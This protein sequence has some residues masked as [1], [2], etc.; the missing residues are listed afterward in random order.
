MRADHITET[1]DQLRLKP[2]H[3]SE[4]YRNRINFLRRSLLEE[5]HRLDKHLRHP[6][7]EV[8][9]AE[10]RRAATRK[11]IAE[12]EERVSLPNGARPRH[13]LR[14]RREVACVGAGQEYARTLVGSGADAGEGMGLLEG[15]S[16][17]MK[18]GKS[19][20]GGHPK[21]AISGHLKTGH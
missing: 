10:R 14:D 13:I 3:G 12:C 15:Y 16:T 2:K 6:E 11:E 21:P 17:F 5:V 9:S 1:H 8:M 19:A 18:A 7:T 20:S 4:S